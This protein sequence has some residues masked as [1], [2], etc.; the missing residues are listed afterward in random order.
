MDMSGG[1]KFQEEETTRVGLSDKVAK[2]K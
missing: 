1:D 2:S